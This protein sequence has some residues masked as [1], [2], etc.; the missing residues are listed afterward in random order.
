M[1]SAKVTAGACRGSQAGY[2]QRLFRD[3]CVAG[4]HPS[5]S[6]LPWD[7]ALKRWGRNPGAEQWY[8]KMDFL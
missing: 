2:H 6:D 3:L 5:C 8:S 7:K 1:S 4:K